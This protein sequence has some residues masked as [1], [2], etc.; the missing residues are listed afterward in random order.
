M[1][2][3]VL[4]TLVMIGA[5][6]LMTTPAVAQPVNDT[7]KVMALNIGLFRF[8]ITEALFDFGD[9]NSTGTVLAGT[10]AGVTGVGRTGGDD[11]GVY[12]ASNAANWTCGSA[13][14]RTVTLFLNSMSTFGT[15]ATDVTEDQLSVQ[16][17]A[18]VGNSQGFVPA[19][20]KAA[21]AGGSGDLINSMSVGFGG[22]NVDGTID[23]QLTVDDDD[24]IGSMTWDLVITAD[25]P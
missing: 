1:K 6:V 13:P 4:T 10:G 5:G 11:G 12:R 3:T 24:G 22:N 19:T 25:A 21:S 8:E 15:T 17:L 14:R 7:L 9:V 20:D 2:R 16:V 18:P 23:L